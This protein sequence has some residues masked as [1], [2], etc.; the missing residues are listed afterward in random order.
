M[1]SFSFSFTHSLILILTHSLTHSSACQH[2]YVRMWL[3]A[4]TRAR[5]PRDAEAAAAHYA[6]GQRGEA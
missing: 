2:T 3:L 1:V 6:S 4:C 5:A